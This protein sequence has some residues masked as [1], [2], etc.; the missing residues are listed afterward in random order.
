MASAAW[1]LGSN[2]QKKAKE[3]SAV[4][5]ASGVTL[6]S[7]KEA[8]L[9]MDVEEW[10][11]TY[12]QNALLKALQ[13]SLAFEGVAIA[14]DSGLSVDALDGAPGVYSAR[15]AGEDA[16]DEANNL[17]LQAEL[18]AR[19]NAPRGASYHCMIAVAAPVDS[20]DPRIQQLRTHT[21][22][23]VLRDFDRLNG[24]GAFR[25]PAE[26]VERLAGRTTPMDV[27]LFE[28]QWFGAIASEAKG[29]SGFGYDPW[30]LLA[31]GRHVAELPDAEKNSI[32]HRAKALA[33]LAA[34]FG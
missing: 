8:G 26:L 5:H 30:F 27:W 29:D 10:G 33:K 12:A 9:V 21:P 15:F 23:E 1:L 11:T 31:D 17:K 4:L 34:A 20:E 6:V 32:S 2:N 14:D 18:K 25:V 7:L 13:F 19:P 28:G 16:T 24:P 22:P 3:L